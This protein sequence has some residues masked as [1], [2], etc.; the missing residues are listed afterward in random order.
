MCDK[1]NVS[2]IPQCDGNQSLSESSCTNDRVPNNPDKIACA[3]HLPT[4]ATYNMRS[5]FP[6]IGNLK[7][8]LK[9]RKIDCAFM[10]EIWEKKENKNHKMQIEKMLELDGLIYM[11]TPRPRGWGG[12]AI[13]VNQEKF[14][15]E[16]LNINIPDN[17]EIVWAC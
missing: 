16:K 4:V 9:E 2:N 6:K 12:A 1:N 5:L 13:I 8:D 15:V 11:S 3:L 7:T 17:L 10:S 14:T